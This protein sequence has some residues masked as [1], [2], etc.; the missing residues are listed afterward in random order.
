MDPG[1]SV[2]VRSSL[3][4]KTSNIHDSCS[5]FAACCLLPIVSISTTRTEILTHRD[6]TVRRSLRGRRG[7]HRRRGVLSTLL[8]RTAQRIR[9]TSS[10]P[11][12]THPLVVVPIGPQLSRSHP[13]CCGAMCARPLSH[14][15]S[16]PRSPTLPG[17]KKTARLLERTRAFSSARGRRTTDDG[18][19]PRR[20]VT[21]AR[22]TTIATLLRSLDGMR[23]IGHFDVHG[24]C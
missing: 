15:P 17:N 10:A 3:E 19:L 8:A 24:V 20:A 23:R 16:F 21:E 11:Y 4:G 12:A 5:T 13:V 6:G 9:G 1:C 22:G 2:R 7:T 14:A 18:N